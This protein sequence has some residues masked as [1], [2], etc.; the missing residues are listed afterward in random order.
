VV[1]TYRALVEYD[2]TLYSGF[3][4]QANR[5]TIQGELERVLER[6]L[7]VPVR[8]TGA[9]RTDAGV[10]AHGQVISFRAD[11]SHGLIDLQRA[12]NALLPSDIAVRDLTGMSPEFHARYSAVSREYVYRILDSAV[13]A[14]LWERY[15]YRATQALVLPAMIEAARWLEGTHDYAAFG[16]PP[17]GENT[18]RTV[19]R[20]CWWQSRTG[21]D[22]PKDTGAFPLTCFSIEAN[23]F[24]RGMVRRIVGTLLMVGQGQLSVEEF[25]A[26][27]LAG[28]ISRA[29][30]PAPAHGLCLWRVRYT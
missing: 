28:E 24:L 26:I 12:M 13:R 6:L 15:A 4:V 16:Q 9:G 19:H 7:Q 5:P 14:P 29:A 25:R 22:T 18:I 10:H 8:I 1:D 27:L 21:W 20:V 30:P 3:Q 11:W 2:G 17:V 23:A